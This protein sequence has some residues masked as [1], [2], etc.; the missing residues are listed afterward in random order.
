[1]TTLIDCHYESEGFCSFDGYCQYKDETLVG[2]D[3]CTEYCKQY[4]RQ[5][6]DTHADLDN[7][8]E[9]DKILINKVKE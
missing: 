5:Y 1:M 4:I 2:Y 7:L 8:T 9:A 6:Y 3:I